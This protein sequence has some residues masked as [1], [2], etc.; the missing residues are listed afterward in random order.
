MVGMAV[1]STG[2]GHP[3]P[4]EPGCRAGNGVC[5]YVA[6]APQIVV[7]GIGAL[8][9]GV[10]DGCLDVVRLADFCRDEP[11]VDH[12]ERCGRKGEAED[13]VEPSAVE[14]RGEVAAGSR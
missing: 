5:A 8:G 11:R 13:D 2:V 10:E 6:V 1:S 12:P 9:V 7:L 4:A 14:E 3:G